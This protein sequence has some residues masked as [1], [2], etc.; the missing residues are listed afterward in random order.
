L[1]TKLSSEALVASYSAQFSTAALRYFFI[2]GPGQARGMLI[3]R[4]YDRVTNGEALGLQG[5]D[6]MRINPVHVRDAAAAT[7]AAAALT[8]ASTVN[9]AGPETLSLR[10][11]G[12]LFAADSSHEAVFE[13]SPGVPGDLIASTGRMSELLVPPAITLRD[14]LPDIRV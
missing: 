13:Q 14:A 8:G 2:Y 4:L 12:E 10:R 6:G 9:V 11:I 5:E 7:I 3:P 1:A